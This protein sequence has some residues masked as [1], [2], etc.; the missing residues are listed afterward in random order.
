M[1]CDTIPKGLD[2]K[3]GNILKN[4]FRFSLFLTC[5]CSLKKK[6]K[7]VLLESSPRKPWQEDL[8]EE[9]GGKTESTYEETI[10]Q[11]QSKGLPN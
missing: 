5:M 1:C 9:V 6:K 10:S 11:I 8:R 2:G 4:V 3:E 7:G